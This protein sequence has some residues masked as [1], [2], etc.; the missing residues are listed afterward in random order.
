MDEPSF[1]ITNKYYFG[2][3]VKEI[4]IFAFPRTGSHLFYYCCQGLFD[5]IT[6]PHEQVENPE[7]IAR[8]AELNPI[9]LYALR[10]RDPAIPYQPVRL[11]PSRTGLHGF[12]LQWQNPSCVLIRDPVATAYSFFRVGFR[13][14]LKHRLS[15]AWI[16][17][18]FE[19]FGCFYRKAWDLLQ[20]QPEKT[21][22]VRYEE[23]LA[24]PRTLER[25]VEFV[26]VTPKLKPGFVY[27]TTRFKSMV[28]PGDRS[29]YREGK[30][31]AW[32][33]DP[34]WVEALRGV[35]GFDFSE[36]GYPRSVTAA[37]DAQGIAGSH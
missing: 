1:A 29:F 19:Q 15:T 22:L 34:E 11:N 12:A 28:N 17:E 20:S 3:L 16:A 14:G 18:Q 2:T 9:S 10:L 37:V 13:W 36:F 21:L 33:S 27:N 4:D 24:G 26:G 25:L 23:L 31:L 30:N 7:A 8:Q 35:A 6:L 5:L 32:R